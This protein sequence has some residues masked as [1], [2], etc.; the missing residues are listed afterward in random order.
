MNHK[1][2][3]FQY[4]LLMALLIICVLMW[5]RPPPG[6]SQQFITGV[7]MAILGLLNLRSKSDPPSEKKQ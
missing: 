5:I 2:E 1:D 6:E 7:G 4:I 3:Y